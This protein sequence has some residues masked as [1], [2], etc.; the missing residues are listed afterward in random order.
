MNQYI[1]E[2]T[3]TLQ[4]QVSVE[5]DSYEEAVKKVRKEYDE[6]EIVLNYLDIVDVQFHPVEEDEDNDE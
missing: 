2:I 5:A 4:R 3:E 1:I 6:E